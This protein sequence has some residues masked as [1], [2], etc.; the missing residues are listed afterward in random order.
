MNLKLLA[1]SVLVGASALG[2]IVYYYTSTQSHIQKLQIQNQQLDTALQ[3]TA[4]SLERLQQEHVR[5]Y[6]IIADTNQKFSQ[7]KRQNDQL[8]DSVS[9]DRLE[10]LATE[11]PGLI[12]K[13][14]NSSTRDALRCLE[15]LSGAQLTTEEINAKTSTEFNSQ[16]PWLYIHN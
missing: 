12:E 14:I 9:D 7:I 1:V 8:R 6:E 16:C 13:S 15:L 10:R 2:G 3:T 11:K 4:H 5:A